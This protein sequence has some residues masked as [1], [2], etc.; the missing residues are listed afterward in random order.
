MANPVFPLLNVAFGHYNIM[1]GLFRKGWT[2]NNV[3]TFMTQNVKGYRRSTVQA[4]RRK[5]LDVLKFESYFRSIADTTLPSHYKIP[6]L[7][8]NRHEKYRILHNFEVLD[9]ETGEIKT[10]RG[11]HYSNDYLSKAG[12]A[13]QIEVELSPE[14]YIIKGEILNISITQVTHKKG[15]SY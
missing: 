11:S 9:L 12:Y 5:V 6:D 10:Y 7:E 2:A 1:E 15:F 13:Q 14:H 4:V 3:Q 8:W